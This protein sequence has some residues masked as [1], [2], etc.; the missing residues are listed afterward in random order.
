VG[1]RFVR[2]FFVC[3]FDRPDGARG[4]CGGGGAH[5]LLSKMQAA[6]FSR[7]E[8]WESVMVTQAGCMGLCTAG[9]AM[10][11]YPEGVWYVGVGP[12]EADEIIA[13]HLY[14]GRVVERLVYRWPGAEE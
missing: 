1:S 10:V 2:H 6:L 12:A 8:L 5:A 14:E 4:S 9:P 3:T 7:P 11:V 13:E